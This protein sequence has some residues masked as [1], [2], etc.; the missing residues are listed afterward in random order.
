MRSYCPTLPK[1][2]PPKVGDSVAVMTTC[3]TRACAGSAA[4]DKT[5]R[6]ATQQVETVVRYF[7]FA[8]LI[9][10]VIKIL[11]GSRILA[12]TCTLP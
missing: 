8:A 1:L 10:L 11:P 3:T 9:V 5:P 6:H 12:P 7:V 4:P 2:L